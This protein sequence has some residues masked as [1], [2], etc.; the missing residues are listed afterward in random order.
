MEDGEVDHIQLIPFDGP[1]PEISLKSP[2]HSF[3]E[4]NTWFDNSQ[5]IVT[6][7][8]IQQ[9]QPTQHTLKRG[10]TPFSDACSLL[11]QEDI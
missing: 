11:E 3:K 7:S 5:E 8:T 2:S 4:R 1:A 6:A 10:Q 9:L